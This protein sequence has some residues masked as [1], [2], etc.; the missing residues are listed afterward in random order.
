MSTVAVND[1]VNE[2]SLTSSTQ[3]VWAFSQGSP[4]GK[5]TW[6]QRMQSTSFVLSSTDI[7]V[8]IYRK[9]HMR[10]DRRLRLATE[11][12]RR[13]NSTATKTN[14]VRRP[15]G[16]LLPYCARITSFWPPWPLGAGALCPVRRIR[17]RA[18]N[19]ERYTSLRK[20]N[21]ELEARNRWENGCA[22]GADA[23]RMKGGAVNTLGRMSVWQMMFGTRNNR[24]KFMT[25]LFA[26]RRSDW[27][28]ILSTAVKERLN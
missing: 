28:I 24:V 17:S 14:S 2:G 18:P 1:V 27:Y 10:R 15:H 6:H 11:K 20:K 5:R 13:I 7:V 22:S 26:I 21:D 23:K 8:T 12:E 25:R 19:D 16:L 9:W 3:R 4:E